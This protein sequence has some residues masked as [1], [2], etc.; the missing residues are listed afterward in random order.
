MYSRNIKL[1]ENGNCWAKE[2]FSRPIE[3]ARVIEMGA[4]HVLCSLSSE[5]V[6]LNVICPSNSELKYDTM[7]VTYE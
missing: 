5:P 3:A 4:N 6:D 2:R 1:V 7:S